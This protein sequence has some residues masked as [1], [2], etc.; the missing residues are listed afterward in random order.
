MQN[1]QQPVYKFII[2]TVGGTPEPIVVSMLSERPEKVVFVT[3]HETQGI[4]HPVLSMLRDKGF[5]IQPAQYKTVNVSEPENFESCVKTLR[6]LESEVNDWIQRGSHFKLAVDFTGGT[7][8]MSAALVLVANRWPAEYVYVGGSQRNKG[9][10]GVVVSGTERVLR[11]ANPWDSLGYQAEEDGALFF[12]QSLYASAAHI[13]GEAAR[14]A[15]RPDVKRELST[16]KRLAEAYDAWDRFDFHA[17]KSALVDVSKH[18]NDL[19]KAFPDSAGELEGVLPNHEQLLAKLLEKQPSDLWIRDLLANA[20]RRASQGSYDDAVARLYRAV[21]A[22]G[23]V[24]LEKHGL[25]SKT[26]LSCLPPN[27]HD[28]WRLRA[29]DDGYLRL[30][31]RDIYELLR[32]LKDEVGDAF[33]SSTLVGR[34]S[35]LE[36]RNNSILAHGFDPVTEQGFQSLWVPV[37]ELVRARENELVV[38]PKL[39]PDK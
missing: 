14:R 31:L 9:G 16:L 17:A 8:C 12:D 29:H 23:Q 4:V 2:Y 5:E 30:G 25:K 35:P 26:A 3:S 28:K 37:L 15:V 19:R 6:K 13:F 21:E 34:Q 11:R 22:Y 36:T 24:A 1:E 32:D 7:K 20:R 39:R 27:L 18:M 10:V 38:F 33:F